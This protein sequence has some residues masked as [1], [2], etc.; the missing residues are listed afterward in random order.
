MAL[1]LERFIRGLHL[2]VAGSACG[3]TFDDASEP[4]LP[5]RHRRNGADPRGSDRRNR[6]CPSVSRLMQALWRGL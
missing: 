5:S 6:T 3:L 2:A 1:L 4:V